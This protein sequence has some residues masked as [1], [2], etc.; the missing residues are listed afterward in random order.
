MIVEIWKKTGSELTELPI[1]FTVGTP[2]QFLNSDGNLEEVPNSPL[3]K[4]INF[5]ET[6]AMGGKAYRGPCYVIQLVDSPVRRIIP[7]EQI[8]EV[9]W[10]NDKDLGQNSVSTPPLED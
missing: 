10:I 2:P 8:E 1:K 7:S 9:A 4:T 3:V 5:Y 6:G